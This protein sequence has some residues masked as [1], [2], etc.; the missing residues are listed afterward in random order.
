MDIRGEGYFMNNALF[1][2]ID[3]L[4]I[5]T[6]N[7][8][9]VWTKSDSG[10]IINDFAKKYCV[11]NMLD[12][13]CIYNNYPSRE[14][15]VFNKNRGCVLFYNDGTEK[16]YKYDGLKTIEG[17]WFYVLIQVIWQKEKQVELECKISDLEFF[18]REY[19]SNEDYYINREYISELEEKLENKTKAYKRLEEQY[20]ILFEKCDI[21]KL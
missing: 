11:D 21:D 2:T 12:I 14:V 5:E 17:H 16:L 9:C 20:N 3:K 8:K 10:I 1:S 7:G 13:E 18:E 4:L 6:L 15:L 19:Y